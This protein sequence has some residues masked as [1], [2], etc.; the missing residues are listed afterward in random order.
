LLLQGSSEA[1]ASSPSSP[2]VASQSPSSSPSSLPSSCSR[3]PEPYH[4]QLMDACSEVGGAG[5]GG[6]CGGATTHPWL[7]AEVGAHPQSVDS[8]TFLR[9]ALRG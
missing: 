1:K 8:A 2:T 9:P 7:P 5:Q 6:G 3:L 4:P